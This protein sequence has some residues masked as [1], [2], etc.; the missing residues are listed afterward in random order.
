MKCAMRRPRAPRT[1]SGRFFVCLAAGVCTALF[2][3]P[4]AAE[5]DGAYG[6]LEGDLELRFGAGADLLSGQPMFSARFDALYLCTAGFYASYADAFRGVPMADRRSMAAGI[7]LAPLFLG[8]F[9]LNREQGPARLD[10]LIDS[11][12]LDVGAFFSQG[13]APASSFG[14]RPGLELGL[15]ISLPFF[16]GA[17]GLFTDLGA[18]LRWPAPYLD[19]SAR[20]QENQGFSAMFSLRL[21]WHQIVAAHW[22]DAADRHPR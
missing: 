7:R 16:A 18:A 6:R 10:L 12:A 19:A 1:K 21:S 11:F 13:P 15:G 20:A 2:C 5:E 8:R 17:T 4:L 3:K 9:A 14:T 22:V